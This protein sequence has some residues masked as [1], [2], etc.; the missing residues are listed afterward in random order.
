VFFKSTP[1]CAELQRHV[2]GPRENKQNPLC[3]VGLQ[4]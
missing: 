4:S 1:V 2:T 3:S